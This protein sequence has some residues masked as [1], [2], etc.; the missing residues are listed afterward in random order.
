M[1]E[2]L[3]RVRFTLED[4]V[5]AFRYLER[6]RLWRW[7]PPELGQ[8]VNMIDGHLLELTSCT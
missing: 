1:T 5:V 7:D 2:P 3:V 4:V 8:H 6:F